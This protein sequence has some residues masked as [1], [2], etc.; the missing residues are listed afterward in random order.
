MGHI[1]STVMD[2]IYLAAMWIAGLALIVMT[3]I[4]PVGIFARY[5]LNDGLSWPEPV[6]ILCMVTFSFVGAAVGYRARSH[7]AVNMLTDRLSPAMKKLCAKL[8]ELM[9]MVIS[10]FIF[11]Y[12]LQLCLELWEQ[13]VA[14]FPLITA[15]QTYLPMP[16]GSLVTLLF[17]VESLFRGTQE[18]RPIVMLGNTD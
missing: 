9:M 17:I 2:A 6:A 10:L 7:I 4:I 1:Y 5:V 8:A 3:L 11:Y 12:S 13:P 15:G 14:E 18:H 16:I